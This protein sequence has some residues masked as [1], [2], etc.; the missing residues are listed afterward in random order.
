MFRLTWIHLGVAAMLGLAAAPVESSATVQG[1]AKM[2]SAQHQVI[3]ELK[4]AR[5]LLEKAN[6]DYQGHRAKAVH[7]ITHAIHLLE[8]GKHHPNPQA[9]TGNGN[10]NKPVAAGGKKGKK[11]AGNANKPNE[12]QGE[13][14]AQLKHAI[15]I[16]HKVE[17]QLQG[18][19]AQHHHH[20][21][22]AIHKAIH[23]LHTALKVA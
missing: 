4:S 12:P 3:A 13:S 18:G 2:H 9:A 19:Q 21:S 6:H 20:A 8:H 5:A 1:L 16:L 10:G 22:E 23:E 14:D 15:E 7:E 17:E 11:G